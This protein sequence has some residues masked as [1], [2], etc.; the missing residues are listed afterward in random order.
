[1]IRI[2]AVILAGGKGTRLRPLTYKIPKAMIPIEGKPV[3]E[4]QII[5]LRRYK[6]RGIVLCTGYKHESIERYF[7]KGSRFGVKIKYLRE[8]KLMGTGGA[9]KNAEKT[10][11]GPFVVLSGDIMLDMN[12]KKLIEFHKKRNA[13]VTTVL[14]ETKHPYD[15]D[16]VEV[17]KK[18][19]VIKL[20]GK[21][22]RDKPLP[23]RL[24]NAS[25]YVMDPEIFSFMPKTKSN[26]EK[27]ILSNLVQTGKV[28]GFITSEYIKDMGTFDRLD[29]VKKVLAKRQKASDVE[30]Y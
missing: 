9:I 16:L 27:D 24:A 1:V 13:L 6:I 25:I 10:V 26:F 8:K 22:S 14:H 7:G 2:K 21:P 18:G 23:T 29:E 4:H 20:I 11:D 3:L 30:K 15:S 12:L 28:Y 19:R 5:F 17:D